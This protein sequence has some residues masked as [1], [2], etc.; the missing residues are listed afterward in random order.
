MNNE[1][2]DYLKASSVQDCTGLIPAAP[3]DKEEL[4]SYQSLYPFLP[5]PAAKD[6]TKEL[7]STSDEITVPSYK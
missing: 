4:E 7:E 2:Y 6:V 5:N 1:N 3:Q